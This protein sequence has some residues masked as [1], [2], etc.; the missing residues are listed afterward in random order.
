MTLQDANL[1]QAISPKWQLFADANVLA[2]QATQDILTAA[3]AAIESKGSFHI[4]LAGGTTPKHVY[5]QLALSPS[6]WQ[7]WHIY[8]G[9]ERCLPVDDPERNSVMVKQC[10]LQDVSIPESQVHFMPAELGPEHAAAAYQQVLSDL[11]EFDMV[12]LG[13]GEDGHTASLFPGHL[14]DLEQAVHPVF[15]APK[16]PPERVSLSSACLSN[17]A[18]LLIF[19]TGES[20]HDRVIDWISDV[21]MPVNLIKSNKKAAV[22]CDH[23]AWLKR[24]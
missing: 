17:N 8:L 11:K 20:K 5:K 14:H 13:I 1:D 21:P 23:T 10:L 16:A 4:V 19:I 6:D 12:L 22:Y 3:A 18:N 7:N 24:N 15:N 2:E 9:D